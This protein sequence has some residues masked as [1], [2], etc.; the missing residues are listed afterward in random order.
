V[1]YY[2]SK[3]VLIK[4]RVVKKVLLL[5]HWLNFDTAIGA[6]I[7][8]LF[9][10]RNINTHVPVVAIA[11]LALTVLAIYNFDHLLDAKQI[12]GVASTGRHKYYQENFKWLSIYELVL[13]VSL[14]I[15]T[16]FVPLEIVKAGIVLAVISLIYFLL[17]F[18]IMPNQ[19]IFKEVVIALV[20]VSGLFL[21]PLAISHDYDMTILFLWGQIFLLALANTFIFAWFD[22][23]V[24]RQEGHTSLAQALGK[25]KIY[26]LSLVILSILA[27]T[28]IVDGFIMVNWENQLIISLMGVMLLLTLILGKYTY[29]HELYRVVGEAIFLIP[30]IGLIW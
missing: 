6:A 2:C 7:T 30:I 27:L 15:I 3:V 24:D 22:Y 18:I 20:F 21:S 9:I 4:F 1:G 11:A 16:L 28:V 10:A 12:K 13:L 23:E 5:L 19:F 26:F 17:L 25:H 14:L 8:S 29:H